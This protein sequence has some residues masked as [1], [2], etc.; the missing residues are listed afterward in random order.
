[1]GF[2]QVRAAALAKEGF[3]LWEAGKLEDA[4]L[5]YVAALGVADPNHRALPDYHG[6]FA[7]VLATLGRDAEA[8]KQYQISLTHAL[9][10]DPGGRGPA[11]AVARYSLGE[12]LLKMKQPQH[13]LHV[14]TQGISH[15]G[16]QE[17][18]LRVVEARALWDLGRKPESKQSAELALLH[19]PSEAKAND[20][21]K[22]LAEILSVSS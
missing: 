16:A 5:K 6:E 11:V 22:Y 10:Q 13:A 15:A 20:L 2:D 12:Q 3:D 14:I 17:W 18:L 4:L 1:M 9:R 7:G 21:R 8:R 19:A